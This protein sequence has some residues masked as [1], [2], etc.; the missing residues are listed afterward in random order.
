MQHRWIVVLIVLVAT[1]GTAVGQGRIV[2][3]DVERANGETVPPSDWKNIFFGQFRL[4]NNLWGIIN[5]QATFE[6]AIYVYDS[7]QYGYNWTR[8]SSSSK[9]ITYPAVFYGMSPWGGDS[10]TPSLPVSVQS[11]RSLIAIHDIEHVVSDNNGNSTWDFAY[12]IWITSKKPDGTDISSTITDEVMVWFGWNK[13]AWTPPAVEKNAV[14]DGFNVY[15]YTATWQNNPSRFHM[16]RIT[17]T[18]HIPEKVDLQPFLTYVAKKYN[19]P[20]L[21]L[22]DIELGDETYDGT[23]GHVLVKKLEYQVQLA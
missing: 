1:I 12:D 5:A 21:W 14:N 19:R 9:G 10:T 16:F 17:G 8:V 2:Q 23:S 20:Q 18:Q 3:S 22:A 11:L 13:D 6:Q 15:Y 4:D 7:G